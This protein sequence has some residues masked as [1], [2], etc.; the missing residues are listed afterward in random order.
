MNSADGPI[1]VTVEARVATVVLLREQRRNAMTRAMVRAL[2]ATLDEV[3]GD[4]DVRAIVVT[5]AGADFS[6]GADLSGGA[7]TFAEGPRDH[8]DDHSRDIGGVL[9]LRLFACRKPVIAAVNGAA[10]GIGATMTL[11][12]DVRLAS[13][14]ARFVFPFSRRGIVPET[15][16][17]WFLP[18]V[19]GI[20][21]AVEWVVSGAP[22]SAAEA[23]GAG[24]VRAL[25]PPDDLL[26]AAQ[27][28]AVRMTQHSSPVSVAAARQLLWQGLTL[29]HPM[30][31]HRQES[32]LLGGLGS[33]AD[34]VEGVTAF[35]E[36]RPAEFTSRPSVDLQPFGDPWRPPPF[37]TVE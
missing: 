16:S 37:E 33:G 17:S 12:M 4:D 23:L 1:G 21:R 3:D 28:L 7:R 30:Q 25:H 18:R 15:C 10:A 5:G 31:A 6:V 19:V 34:A 36:H 32:A 11:P 13:T 8:A 29:S 24:L 35:L 26:A 20:S 9:A 14:T 2:I 22:V 27:E